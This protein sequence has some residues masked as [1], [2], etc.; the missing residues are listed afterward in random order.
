MHKVSFNHRRRTRIGPNA[1]SII[2]GLSVQVVIQV[3]YGGSLDFR[4][5]PF[6]PRGRVTRQMIDYEDRSQKHD[7]N[8][9]IKV[10][11]YA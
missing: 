5:I 9:T 10:N 1:G 8:F 4:D 7:M 6:Y 3:S 2:A 11:L